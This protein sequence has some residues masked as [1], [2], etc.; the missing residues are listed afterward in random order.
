[1]DNIDFHERTDVTA[2]NTALSQAL[3]SV[4]A[5]LPFVPYLILLKGAFILGKYHGLKPYYSYIDFKCHCGDDIIEYRSCT[6]TF[7]SRPCSKRQAGPPS[8][9][10]SVHAAPPLLPVLV[11]LQ[12]PGPQQPP[13]PGAGLCPPPGLLLLL[14]LV[15]HPAP[16]LRLLRVS[17]KAVSSLLA[18]ILKRQEETDS[19]QSGT[20]HHE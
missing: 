7:V 5:L 17:L 19:G 14:P 2:L 6:V 20:S 3:N 15:L 11:I 10:P 13:R 1:M 8:R 12:H 4:N 16:G 18:I 9:Q